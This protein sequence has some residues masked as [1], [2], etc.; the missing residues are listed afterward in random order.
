[1]YNVNIPRKSNIKMM[2]QVLKNPSITEWNRC[3]KLFKLA[4][5]CYNLQDKAVGGEYSFNKNI[6]SMWI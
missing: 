4:N 6:L 5:F 1:M 3:K 2:K